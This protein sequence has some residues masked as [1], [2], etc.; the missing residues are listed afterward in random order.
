MQQLLH[1]EYFIIKLF[2]KFQQNV[3][4]LSPDMFAVNLNIL[5]HVCCSGL[6][7]F[8]ILL[9]QMSYPSNFDTVNLQLHMAQKKA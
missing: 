5:H 9:L 4:P 8:L 7:D 2:I 1:R 3:H 6:T